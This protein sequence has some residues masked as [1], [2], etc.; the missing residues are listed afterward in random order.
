M[1]LTHTITQS[2]VIPSSD[3]AVRSLNGGNTNTNVYSRV[4]NVG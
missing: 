1:R 2:F 4:S 3:H